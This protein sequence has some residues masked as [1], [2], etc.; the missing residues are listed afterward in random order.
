MNRR[1]IGF[2]VVLSLVFL[3]AVSPAMAKQT[4]S[5]AYS[6]GSIL[7]AVVFHAMGNTASQMFPGSTSNL[8]YWLVLVLIVVLVVVVCG[9]RRL[10]REHRKPS[11]AP[12]ALH[13]SPA[14]A[15]T[16]ES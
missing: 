3:L 14:R 12:A 4:G 11:P 5:G 1:T 6:K 8:F 16:E 9:P 15:N 2:L 7:V 13:G 10:V